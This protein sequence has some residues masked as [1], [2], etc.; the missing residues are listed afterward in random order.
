MKG[1][2]KQCH[3]VSSRFVVSLVTLGHWFPLGIWRPF[4]VSGGGTAGRIRPYFLSFSRNPRVG[5][6]AARGA[7]ETCPYR[8]PRH[9]GAP[10][11]IRPFDHFITPP[12]SI[13]TN[14]TRF[15]R[16]RPLE[17]CA[18]F[19]SAARLF[20]SAVDGVLPLRFE[21]VSRVADAGCRLEFSHHT[22]FPTIF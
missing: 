7:T 20:P 22:L 8:I 1:W 11:T 16:G 9:R 15:V 18:L 2:Y 10:S 12:T 5:S 19:Q 14:G 17:R 21:D 4:S 6:R 3:S 13:D